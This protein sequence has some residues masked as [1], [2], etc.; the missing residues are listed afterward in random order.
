MIKSKQI[1]G[2]HLK[3][4]IEANSFSLSQQGA[5]KIVFF[6][7]LSFALHVPSHLIALG[8][9]TDGHPNNKNNNNK[10]SSDMRSVPD[11]KVYES[12]C[13]REA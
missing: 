6:F 12:K 3:F 2:H 13:E 10:M 4:R 11:L 8:F 7:F 5:S 1:L 9:S